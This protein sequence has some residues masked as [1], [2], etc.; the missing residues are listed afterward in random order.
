MLTASVDMSGFNAGMAGLIQKCGLNSR[1]VVAKEAGELIKELIRLTP[2][3]NPKKTKDS[4]SKNVSTKF[5]ALTGTLGNY[6]DFDRKESSSGVKWYAASRSFLF[7]VARDSDMR[8]ASQAELMSAYYAI[9]I[10]RAHV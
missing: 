9:K 1:V 3:K 2:P 5:S 4:I 7:G 8:K 6:E 10:G